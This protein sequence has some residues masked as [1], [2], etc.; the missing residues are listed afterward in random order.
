MSAISIP[1]GP[2]M[3]ATETR[4]PTHRAFAIRKTGGHINDLVEIGVAWPNQDDSGFKLKLNTERF[5]YA[6][7]VMR[8]IHTDGED[9][10]TPIDRVMSIFTTPARQHLLDNGRYQAAAKATGGKIDFWP[11]VKLNNLIN[12]ETFLL[13]EIES[14]DPTIAWGLCD[15]RVGCPAFG[16]ISLIELFADRGRFGHGI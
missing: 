4:R 5:G 7:I 1:K 15:R 11:V 16:R 13:T 3:T 8:E 6:T 2:T 9:A 10:A 14:E 12:G